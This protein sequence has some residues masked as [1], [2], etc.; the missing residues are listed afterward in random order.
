MN[1]EYEIAKAKYASLG[2]DTEK[3]LSELAGIPISIHCWQGDDVTGFE[4]GNGP[5]GGILATG[6]YPYKARTPKELMDDIDM[7]L[8]LN[9]GTHKI[10]LH[11]CYAVFR[12]GEFADRD[13]LK[14]AHF[15]PWAEFAKKRKIGIDFNPTFFS[16]PK[17]RG[18]TLTNPD[19]EI[20]GFWV[21]HGI[22]CLRISEYFAEVTGFPCV[23]NIWIPDGFK[24][25]PG[26]RTGP[27]K[28]YMKSLDEILA[29]GYDRDKVFVTLESKVFGIGLESYTAGSAE[30]T[31]GYA[32]TRNITP[33]MDNGHYHPTERVS[34]KI[35]SLL[36]VSKKIALHLTRAVRWDSDHVVRLD[37]ETVEI[38]KEI[39]SSGRIDDIFISLDYFDGSINRIAAWTAGIRNVRKALLTAMLMPHALFGKLQDEGRFT[40]LFVR[41]E[42]LKSMPA[43]AVFDEY[44]RRCGVAVGYEWYEKVQKYE[45]EVL[46]KRR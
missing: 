40:E 36:L 13:A 27:R 34:D 46:S 8:S 37:D 11:A 25:I 1:P 16:H 17:A 10:N 18:L 35:S 20:R 2:I 26:D 42:E 39:V 30:F 44:C 33:L 6:N 12:D 43:G 5:D 22:A 7:V 4:S 32:L 29:A 19:E 14:P 31:L 38:A 23:M 9:G 3:A 21:K 15:A 45:K 24:D 41:Q 28:R